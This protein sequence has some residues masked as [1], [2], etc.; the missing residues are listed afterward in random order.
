MP[1]TGE[2]RG[3]RGNNMPN[4]PTVDITL[5][6]SWCYPDHKWEWVV[7]IPEQV[8]IQ[9][10]AQ[11]APDARIT[12]YR[13]IAVEHVISGRYQWLNKLAVIVAN[14]EYGKVTALYKH[15]FACW[16]LRLRED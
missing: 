4:E 14:D 12:P 6:H 10:I 8:A 1:A 3:K 7:Q 2:R 9:W 5:G 15:D 13:D 11:V 16:V